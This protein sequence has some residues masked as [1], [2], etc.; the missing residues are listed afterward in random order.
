MLSC[1]ILI[2]ETKHTNGTIKM[3]NLSTY[4]PDTSAEEL[5]PF[6]DAIDWD[7][8]DEVVSFHVREVAEEYEDIT[9]EMI[10]EDIK[11]LTTVIKGFYEDSH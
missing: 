9:E 6:F 3:Q 2:T 10:D 1:N 4:L 11:N 7:S 8:L 5:K